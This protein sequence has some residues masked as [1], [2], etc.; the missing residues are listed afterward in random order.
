MDP[1]P[2]TISCPIASSVIIRRHVANK[3]PAT[4]LFLHYIVWIDQKERMLSTGE[5]RDQMQIVKERWSW[6]LRLYRRGS[7]SGGAL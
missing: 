2:R 1:S 5:G 6:E 7:T 4:M 3:Y